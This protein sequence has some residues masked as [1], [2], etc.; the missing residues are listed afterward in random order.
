MGMSREIDKAQTRG[1]A[2]RFEEAMDIVANEF[3]AL[4]MHQQYRNA[5]SRLLKWDPR[6][7]VLCLAPTNVIFSCRNFAK[8]SS[9]LSLRPWSYSISA[10]VTAGPWRLQAMLC[11]AARDFPSRIRI[12]IWNTSIAIAGSSSRAVIWKA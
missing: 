11:P 5:F 10:A 12:R 6:G 7:R 2:A 8:R 4:D 3:T 1:L 9:T